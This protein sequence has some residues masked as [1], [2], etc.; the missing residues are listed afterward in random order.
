MI[1]T[2]AP[3]LWTVDQPLRFLG[4]ELG[5][6]MTV[7]RLPGSQLL[8]HSP[9][10]RSQEVAQHIERL[11]SPAFLIAPNRFHH[12]YVSEWQE[13]YPSARLYVAPGLEQKRPDLAVTGVL[14]ESAVPPWSEVL[15][16]VL[17][18]G[19]PFVNEVV[20]FHKPSQTLIA[21]DLAFNIDAGSPALTRLAFRL[22]HAYGR[23]SSTVL[24]RAMIRDRAAFRASLT[25]IL[26]WPISRVI[27]AH[28]S[29]IEHDGHTA[30][31]H[32]YA[33]VLR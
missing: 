11:G 1:R 30:L 32:A 31:A 27:V 18:A 26:H 3:D 12:L 15:E 9:I 21:S 5:T 20:F 10:S 6:R 25:R 23:L 24:E 22:M 16:H 17:V 4:L 8:L 28:G 19:F 13:A 33:W 14:G 29:V 2:L 7:I